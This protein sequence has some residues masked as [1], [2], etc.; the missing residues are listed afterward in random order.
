MWG[1]ILLRGRLRYAQLLFMVSDDL[2]NAAYALCLLE[3]GLPDQWARLLS[4]S[5]ITREDYARHPEAV[6]EVLEFYTD[7][8]NRARER[9][10]PTPPAPAPAQGASASTSTTRQL[11]TPVRQPGMLS[12]LLK[13]GKQTDLITASYL[14]S[15]N[16]GTTPGFPA[17]TSRQI[18]QKRPSKR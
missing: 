15:I 3:Q 13:E 17:P 1:S 12:F 2:I 11:A 18:S 16:H 10:L 7:N 9:A 6:L 5:T 4:S 14:Q 8:Q